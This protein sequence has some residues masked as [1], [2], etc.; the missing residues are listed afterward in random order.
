MAVTRIKNNQI[1]D[2][3]ITYQKIATGTLVGS[4]FNNNLTLNSNISI[5]G[6]L[7]VA[8]N[9]TSINSINTSVNDPLLV[10]NSGYTGS[11]VNYSIG[12][13]I[14]RNLASL[15]A[16]GAVNTAFV[17]SEAEEAFIA[18]AT[19]DLGTGITN[20]DNSGYA[21]IKTGNLVVVT[22]LT[23]GSLSA[24]LISPTNAVITTLVATNLST[25]NAVISGGYINSLSNIN[26]TTAEFTNLSTG[27]AVISGGYLFGL[28][29]I[30]STSGNVDEWYS[31]TLNASAANISGPLFATSFNTANAVITG[32]Y[33]TDMANV[34]AQYI[35]ATTGFYSANITGGF[36]Q[37]SLNGTVPT[38][39]VS[40]YQQ[41]TD[42]TT[43]ASFYLPIY[44]KATG[45]AAAYT[46][47]SLTF[48]PSTGYLVATRFNGNI[49]ATDG[50]ITDFSSGNAVI[51]GGYFNNIANLTSTGSIVSGGNL[52][53][54]SG[55]NATN[56]TTGALVVPGGGGVGITGDL[57]VQGPSTFAGNI[58]AGNIQLSGNINVT[59]GGTFSNTGVF[60]GN[61]GG[62]GALYAGTPTYTALPTTVL[63][64]SANV[65][66]YA[67]VNFQNINSGSSASTDFVL[68]ADNGND[69]D[70]YIDLG[71]NSSTYNDPT[72]PGFY[73]NDGYL[74]HHTAIPSGNLV[75]LSHEDGSAIK[76]HVGEYGDANVRV[77]ITNSGLTVNTTTDSTSL[78]S[79][80][81]IINGGLGVNGNI[82]AAAINNTPI[83]NT[84]P[85]TGNFTNLSATTF[86]PTNFSTGNAVI[87]GG[88]INDL[89]NLTATTAQFTNLS[90]G[91]AVISGGYIS[92]LTNAAITSAGITTGVIT[93]FSTGNAVIIGGYINSLSNINATTAEFTNLSTGNAVI[94]GG[95]LNNV[96][97]GNATPS[98]G[99]FTTLTSSG[100]TTV[101]SDTESSSTSSG[102][103]VVTG[104]V[105]IGKNLNV[106]G[107]AYIAGNLTVSGAVEYLN[108]TVTTIVDPILEL[109]TGAN[110][111]ALAATTT[112][113]S[114]IRTHYYAGADKSSFF[115]R[116]NT[117]EAFEYFGD[118]TSESGNVITGVYG[119]MRSGAL[120]LSNA[121]TVSGGLT[122]NTG[123]LRVWGDGSVSGNLFVGS[124][125]TVATGSFNTFTAVT[126]NASAANV[127][128]PLFATSL[129]TANAVIT[130]GYI[131][132]LSNVNA[133]TAEFTNLSTGNAVISGG[134]IS[135]LSNIT[136]TTGNVSS[137][138][139]TTLNVSSGNVSGPLFTTSINTANLVAAGGYVNDLA[140][141][142]ATTAQFT[143]LSTGNAVIS[144]GYIVVT[145]ANASIGTFTTLNASAGN[146]AG[147]LFATS[148]NTANAVIT[149]GYITVANANAIVG[150]FTTLNS[151]SAN[152]SGPLFATSINTANLVAT[153]GYVNNLSNLT[154]TTTQTTNFST[155]NAVISGGYIN[156]LA[157][158][159]A[160]T[161]QFTNL[162]T[163]NAVISG[164][165]ISAMSNITATTGNVLTWYATTLNAS[166]ANVSGPLYSTSL[167][168][169]NAVITGGYINNLANLTATTAQFDNLST[170]NVLITGGYISS[171]TNAYITTAA[172]TNFS[173]G[174]VL[175][176]GG[177]INDLANL[178]ATTAQFTNLSTGNAVISGGYIS[179]LTNAYITTSAITNFSTANAF[180]TG[181]YADNFP[182][183]SNIA[184]SGTFT[185]LNSIGNLV[186]GSNTPTTSTT[187]G[188]LVVVGGAGFGSNLIVSTGANINVSQTA[189]IG[190]FY[191]S[192]V[193]DK[194]LIWAR[195][196]GTYDQVVIGNSA[197]A[198]GLTIGAK[199]KI[200]T[201]DSIIIPVGTTSQR[202]SS[203]GGADVPGMVRFNTTIGA[204]EFYTG[205]VWNSAGTAL[206]V[207]ATDQFTGDG[208][209]TDFTLSTAASSTSCV[210][211]INGVVQTPIT[212][213][214]VGGI[215]NKTLSFT[216]APA[217]GDTIDVRKL[218]TSISA[219]ILSTGNGLVQVITDQTA[220]IQFYSNATTSTEVLR[221]NTL[222]ALENRTANVSIAT[223]NL[224]TTIDSFPKASYR[225]AK[226]LVQSSTTGGKYQLAE[227]LVI[228]DDTTSYRTVYGVTETNGNVGVFETTISGS[229]VLLQ[230]IASTNNTNVRI[231]KI[232]NPI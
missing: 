134:Y 53:A 212:A 83:G 107:N 187:T 225:S 179:A 143:N 229:N 94:S 96:P 167:N 51:T 45:N 73:P 194:T 5:T 152:V 169:A 133:T 113:D 204:L 8:G 22:N 106:G 67:Q 175:I 178:T 64:M 211:S 128:G 173:T 71:I 124:Q 160:T 38:A 232:Y 9:T 91:N 34:S 19:T 156:D 198:S 98:T 101:T 57:W 207:I 65:N 27:N 125:L 216:E 177:Y 109:N 217:V 31:A 210:I 66:T 180:V 47:A 126:L 93:N 131:N 228:H 40:L 88:Y 14:N 166:S 164:G 86:V 213:Y 95:S 168:T 36:N 195:A 130:G 231:Y 190:D 186:A 188:A 20:I 172:I 43:N 141:L 44:D 147:P 230:Y 60:F 221:I 189:A 226:Y 21:N 165:Y 37:G 105:G 50:Q 80:A 33:I 224:L 154:V 110:G 118:V 102:A 148:L 35:T 115:G 218:T 132:N 52:V 24:N 85:S 48:N 23:T 58:V 159:T 123:I 103:L 39:N 6:N 145:N 32:G 161:A 26:A 16:Y 122:A 74:I 215:D 119:T 59:V 18:V 202:P 170:G 112:N 150:T 12:M 7:T 46:N 90:T 157:N 76:F 114:G 135:D 99:A 127:S 92:A 68:T 41:L 155:G 108:T 13:L 184:A 78:S 42:N 89:A 191:V 144:G 201:T 176:T 63:Q 146:I 29:N 136:A 97:V 185:T 15:G 223:A 138:Y 151:S 182:I 10:Y 183:G 220:G 111:A 82:H 199:L 116:I 121:T 69:T 196:N 227:V 174:N 129:N 62:I 3:T 120:T 17:W 153:G 197:T 117:S 158:L 2:S 206:T 49:Y 181:G 70:G 30:T 209:T 100:A 149:G 192:G 28:A 77:T 104:G 171:L 137:W 56:Y 72:F 162:S 208:I 11:L 193:N 84:T 140:N 163:G 81:L 200:N 142:T 54:N 25:G 61:A 205:A 4:L 75:I 222:G 55:Q 1:T 79:G 87:T 214:S 219:N 203:V 139:A